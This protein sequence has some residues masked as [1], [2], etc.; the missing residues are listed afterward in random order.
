[1]NTRTNKDITYYRSYLP[2]AHRFRFK[3]KLTIRVIA[4]RLGLSH[5]TVHTLFLTSLLE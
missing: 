1:M 3:D 5:S 4:Q 2:D